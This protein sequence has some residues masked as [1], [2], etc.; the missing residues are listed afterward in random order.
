MAW[1][2]ERGVA[3]AV[4][5]AAAL[6]VASAPAVAASDADLQRRVEKRLVQA[7]FDRRADVTV[8][9]DSGVVR[10]TGITVS[11]RDLREAER[12]ARKEAKKVVN[13]LE[14]VPE[15]PR[16]DK[17]IRT[18]VETAVL[19]WERYGPFDAVGVE[20]EKGVVLLDGWVDTPYK[21]DELEERL[22]RVDGIRDVRNDL[23]IQ[24][25]S[26]GDVALRR[27]V[28]E[29]IYRDPLFERW[30]GQPDP[31][32]RVFVDRGRVTLAGTVGSAVEQTAVG[33]IAR[34]TLAFT[35][36]NQVRVEAS[37]PPAE[38]RKRDPGEGE[39]A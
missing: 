22:A 16:S 20:V 4:L 10:L 7:G 25:F 27:Q 32:V 3:V 28:Y 12:L 39:G 29:R 36:D 33:M 18:D 34:G 37:E 11:W 17:A 30:R 1:R 15:E 6:A 19:R 13:V 21:K 23:R 8:E 26:S 24:G 31:P 9:V 5:V 14:V 35:V 38:D 2:R